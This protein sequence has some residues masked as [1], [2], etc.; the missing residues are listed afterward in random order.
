MSETMEFDGLLRGMGDIVFDDDVGGE[1]LYHYDEETQQQEQARR[2][3]P[4]QQRRKASMDDFAAPAM[5]DAEQEAPPAKPAAAAP[6]PQPKRG[7]KTPLVL[8][9]SAGAL[10]TAGVYGYLRWKRPEEEAPIK[11]AGV[12]GGVSGF[13][14]LMTILAA[15][16]LGALDRQ[17]KA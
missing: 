8:G 4:R 16:G 6:A 13:G 9:L 17:A 7:L 1:S 3:P 5:D 15:R 2:S 12:A 14:V 11:L 10:A